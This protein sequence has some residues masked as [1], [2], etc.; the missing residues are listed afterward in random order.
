MDAELVDQVAIVTGGASGIGRATAI[1]LSRA[2]AMVIVGDL[3]EAG[4]RSAAAEA[5]PRCVAT[6]CDVAVAADI[7]QLVDQAEARFGALDIVFGNAGILQTAP[8]EELDVAVFEQHLRINLTANFVLAQRAAPALRRRGGG[9][10]V[11]NASVGGLRGS[12]GSAAYNASKGG[13]INLMRS[14]ADELGPDHIR[15]NC[16]CPGWIETSFNEPFWA[17]AGPGALQRVVAG[18]PL[19]RQ[20]TPEEVAS[21]VVFLAGAGSQYVSGHALVVDGGG[22][23]T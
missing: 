9:S 23:A 8:L 13:L 14:L 15:V 7:E 18:I 16:V 2:G 19:R 1:A 17:H 5:G 6:L 20:A 3:D 10:M 11:F 22:F 21:V 12:A 4:A